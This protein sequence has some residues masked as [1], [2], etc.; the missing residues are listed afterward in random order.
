MTIFCSK[1]LPKIKSVGD[2]FKEVRK[3]NNLTLFQASHLSHIPK[4]HL[5]SLEKNQFQKLPSAK[6]HCIAYVRRYAKILKL[7]EKI[8][9]DEFIRQTDLNNYQP[10]HPHSGLKIRPLNSIILWTKRLAIGA[11]S[12]VFFSYIGWQI[13]GIMRPPTLII[14]TPNEGYVTKQLSATIQGQTDAEISLTINGQKIRVNDKGQFEVEISLSKG[15][16][17][18]TISATKKHGKTSTLTRHVV[19]TPTNNQ[20]SYGSQQPN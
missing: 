14:F 1:K 10:I 9:T 15:V 5:I 6:A 11:L 13:N 20:V 7:D 12:I 4:K 19:A 17:T 2:V 18:I 8:I 16:N 3:K